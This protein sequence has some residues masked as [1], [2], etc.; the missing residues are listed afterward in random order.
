VLFCE[1][2]TC[3][4]YIEEHRGLFSTINVILFS[5]GEEKCVLHE[6]EK[7]LIEY[8]FSANIV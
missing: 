8:I 3:I 1:N 7:H 5:C 6:K 4:I 2:G